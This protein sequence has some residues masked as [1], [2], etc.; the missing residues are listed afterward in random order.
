MVVFP[1]TSRGSQLID[2]SRTELAIFDAGPGNEIRFRWGSDIGPADREDARRSLRD[3]VLKIASDT[4]EIRYCVL[5]SKPRVPE[6][7]KQFEGLYTKPH[8]TK[9]GTRS[10]Y[11]CDKDK[12]FDATSR[13]LS[14]ER[15]RLW[16]NADPKDAMPLER[17]GG[18]SWDS[19]FDEESL[20]SVKLEKTA[21]VIDLAD[22]HPG[23]LSESIGMAK[24]KEEEL[25]KQQSSKTTDASDKQQ[26]KKEQLSKAL[27]VVQIDDIGKKIRRLQR[28][29]QLY[30][31]K[32]DAVIIWEVEGIKLE[33]SGLTSGSSLP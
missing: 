17:R 7:N 32:L 9:A 18:G 25:K 15:C 11:E 31:S 29:F 10:S 23:K 8:Q 14:I 26:L 21:I 33:I 19:R 6:N 3:C 30:N 22:E 28:L 24:Q 4:S 5:R 16:K 12:S 1:A 2:K 20:L 13:K 27:D